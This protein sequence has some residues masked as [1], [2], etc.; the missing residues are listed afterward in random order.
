MNSLRV[1]LFRHGPAGTRD[2]VRWANDEL[3]PLTPRGE[4]R[5][6]SA[7]SRLAKLTGGVRAIWTSPLARAAASAELLRGA[8]EEPRIRTVESL[9]PGGSWRQTIEALQQDRGSGGILV[10][11]GHEPDLG[12]LAGRMVFGAARAL[13]LKKA[14]ACAIDF[15]GPVVPGQGRLAWLLTPKMLRALRLRAA[16]VR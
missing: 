11:V 13:P 2:A 14:G 15:D 10:L 12:E 9:R 7:A 16:R 5:T 1:V 8:Y 6:R 4:S 3:R